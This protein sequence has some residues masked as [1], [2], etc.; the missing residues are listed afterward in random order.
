MNGQRRF[1]LSTL[2]AFA[3]AALVLGAGLA[4]GSVG[5]ARAAP[6]PEFTLSFDGLE[7][8]VPQTDVGTFTLERP[9]DLVLF[10]WSEAVGL[11]AGVDT[12]V[13]ERV[14]LDV[15]VCDAAGMCLDPT[16]L[17]GAVPFAAGTGSLT[18]TAEL[19]AVVAPGEAGSIVGRLAFVAEESGLAATGS[20]T[21]PWL[22]AALAAIAV[23]TLVFALVRRRGDPLDGWSG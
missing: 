11:L 22:A 13:G 5:S 3:A 15:E 18:V 17:G 10:E 2:S 16:T 1:A 9:A 21:A 12:Q 14:V 8:G 4:F 23:G 7:P 19:T 6:A 20:D